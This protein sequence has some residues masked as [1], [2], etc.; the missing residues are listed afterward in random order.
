MVKYIPDVNSWQL[1]FVRCVSQ[2]LSMLPI[3]ICGKHHILGTPDFAT[4]WRVAAQ[5]V[6]GGFLLLGIFEA[7]ARLPLG[8][9]TAIF[10]SAPAFTMVTYI[11]FSLSFIIV[12]GDVLYYSP[13]PLWSLENNGG[14]NTA[15]WGPDPLKTRVFVR[16]WC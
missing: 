9:C 4:R 13:R 12:L 7:V 16:V 5:G 3:I 2:L 1:L 8:D 14:H 11:N 6:L 10:F 15:E